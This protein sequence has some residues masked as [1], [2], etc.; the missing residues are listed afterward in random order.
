MPTLY[1]TETDVR[2]YL[3]KNLT[4]EG[5]NAQPS[6][7]NPS[8]ETVSQTEI[9]YF[10]EQASRYVDSILGALFDVPFKRTNQGGEIDFPRPIKL[11]T[12]IYAAQS[13]YAQRLQ[14]AD[15]QFSDAQKQREDFAK[16]LLRRVQNGE[17]RLIGQRGN[18]GDRFVRSSLRGAPKNPSVDGKST[19]T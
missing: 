1:C 17:V 11:L 12:S 10:I 2:E 19:G 9:I 15:K 14:A 18:K 13:L 7:R 5:D 16:D 4:T 3:P 8:P 6:F